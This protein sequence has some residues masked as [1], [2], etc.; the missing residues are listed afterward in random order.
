MIDALELLSLAI[1]PAEHVDTFPAKLSCDGIDHWNKG[2][3]LMQRLTKV[4]Q[5]SAPSLSTGIAAFGNVDGIA[6]F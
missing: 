4:G 5:I 6:A 1:S 2:E 3:A